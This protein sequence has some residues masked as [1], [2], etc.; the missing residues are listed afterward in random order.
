LG[1]YMAKFNEDVNHDDIVVVPT[2]SQQH[3]GE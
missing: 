1:R 3:V 2:R